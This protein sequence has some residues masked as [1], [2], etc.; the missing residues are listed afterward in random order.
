MTATTVRNVWAGRRAEGAGRR[1][2]RSGAAL[3]A[4]FPELDRHGI[5]N[6]VDR[7]KC[8][9]EALVPAYVARERLEVERDPE[10][11]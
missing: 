5:G 11:S 2:E 7:Q 1:S 4:R 8:V 3:V 10:T 6:R 9:V